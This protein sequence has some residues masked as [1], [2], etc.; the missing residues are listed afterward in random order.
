MTN[1]IILQHWS[2]P[3][4]E[5][6]RLSSENIRLYA[7]SLGVEY[8]LLRGDIFMPGLSSPCQKVGLLNKEFDQYDTVV[9]LDPDM[10]IKKGL[11]ENIFDVP[12][13]GR[14]YN[15][16]ETL[17]RKLTK[18]FP[19]LGDP[20]YPYWGGSIYKFDRDTRIRLRKEIVEMEVAQFSG[21]YED[22]GIFHRLAVRAKLSINGNTYLPKDHWNMS[23]FEPDLSNARIIHIRPKYKQGG[24]KVPKI[25]V[26]EN[27]KKR[28]LI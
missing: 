28:G 5:L 13:M 17:V 15:I 12:G 26:Y 2:G 20:R 6:T 4:N 23:S 1:N 16:Q 25:D 14:H 22:E 11:T 27:L 10:F 21:N 19:H 9:M 7:E 18:R 24:P 3:M 8:R